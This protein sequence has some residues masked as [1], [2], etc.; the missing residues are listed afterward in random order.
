MYTALAGIII[1]CGAR[2]DMYRHRNTPD[3]QLEEVRNLANIGMILL[4]ASGNYQQIT[5]SGAM[6]RHVKLGV[7]A[8]AQRAICGRNIT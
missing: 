4:C 6:S 8:G 5:L 3:R 2:T 1:E 7:D